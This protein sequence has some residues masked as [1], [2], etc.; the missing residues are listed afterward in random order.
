MEWRSALQ[1]DQVLERLKRRP[2]HRRREHFQ[3][4]ADSL[5]SAVGGKFSNQPAQLAKALQALEWPN[6]E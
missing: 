3:D 6:S 4:T 2:A 5:Q 1:V